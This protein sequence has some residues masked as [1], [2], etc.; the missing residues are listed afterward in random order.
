MKIILLKEIFTT[1][2]VVLILHI[3]AL[4]FY[5][6]WTIGWYDILMHFL[7]GFLIGL[8]I[9]SFIRRIH[10]GE[11][12]LNTKLL[13]ISV[14]SGVLV[15][16]LGWELWE[17]FV[18]FTNILKDKGDTILDIIMGL[19]GGLSSVFYYYFKYLE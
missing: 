18:G 15:I 7:G 5:L 12:I 1:A 8:L 2:I 10:V 6:Y 16:A 13:S 3:L 19:G 17:I 4:K 9:I 14:I 11:E